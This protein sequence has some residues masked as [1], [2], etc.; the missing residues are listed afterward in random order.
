VNPTSAVVAVT[1]NCNAR[2]VMCDIWK[3][4]S[5][6]EMQPLAYRNLPASLREINLS[7]GEPFLR[8]DLPEVIAAI[9]QACPQARLV[10]STN[11]LLVDRMLQMAPRLLELGSALAVRVSVDGLEETHDR[12]RGMPG[13]FARALRG[14]EGLKEAGVQD[15][16][17]GMTLLA[18]NVA[19]VSQ[20]YQLAERLGVEFSVTLASD[21]PIY[22]GEGKARLRPH[23]QGELLSQLRRLAWN[24]Y[25]HRQ[26]KRWFRA[27]FERELAQYALHGQ[28][29]LACDAGRGFFYLDPQGS[30]FCCH[31]LP[32]R[33]GSLREEGW[34]SLWLSAE[35]Q[36]ARQEVAGCQA[37]WMVCTAR[38]Q[39][40]RNLPRIGVQALVG[41]IR[42]HLEAPQGG[43]C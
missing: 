28:R 25:R 23:A 19:Q 26:P 29:P 7:G 9:R 1:L 43:A 15:L 13:G 24:E 38:A 18:E 33:L 21:S 31:L 36:A 34:A 39:M 8:Q 40:R 37:C 20:V 6:G 2:C 3:Q 27:W 12:L 35:A 32:H 17:V 22:F 30:V 41:K 16:G 5:V 42:A 14:L 4:R 10:I 11:G